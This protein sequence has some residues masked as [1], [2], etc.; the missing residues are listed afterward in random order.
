M[1]IIHEY[2]SGSNHPNTLV[3]L[4]IVARIF[5]VCFYK[6]N[7]VQQT[8]NIYGIFKHYRT[9]MARNED[10]LQFFFFNRKVGFER[11]FCKER[12]IF[13]KTN[14][15]SIEGLKKSKDKNGDF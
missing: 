15:V 7:Q 10:N 6:D 4:D 3:F 1:S 12:K 14:R 13:P 8:K 5:E 2:I 11:I 9:N